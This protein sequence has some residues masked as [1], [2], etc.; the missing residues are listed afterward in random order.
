MTEERPRPQYG[1]Y[2]SPEDQ[3]QAMGT[4]LEPVLP[5]PVA[6]ERIE[7]TV[8]PDSVIPKPRPWDRIV[9]TALIAIGT[10][11]VLTYFPT[12]ATMGETFS[13]AFTIA[14]YGDF[15]SESLANSVGA[16]LNVVMSVFFIGS[17]VLAIRA[18]RAGRRAFWIPLSAGIVFVLIVIIA[19][20]VVM[21]GDPAFQAYL[22]KMR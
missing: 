7:S 8:A 17:V 4:P 15:E 14:G 10:F 11:A 18:L 12:F 22:E 21:T 20:V 19:T 6:G 1:E 13:Q 5:P 9:T 2:A 16:V 3:A